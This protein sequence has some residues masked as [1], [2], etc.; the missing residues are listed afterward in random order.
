MHCL[1]DQVVRCKLLAYMLQVSMKINIKVKTNRN[2]S[3]VIKK[4]FAEYEVWVKSPPV[5]GLANKE[6]INTLSNYFNV[7]PYNLRIVKGLTSSIKIVEL[8]K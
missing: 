6:L 7:K 3:R 5:K 4:D 1:V 8:T 2:E